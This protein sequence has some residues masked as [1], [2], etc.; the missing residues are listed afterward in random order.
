MRADQVTEA[1]AE[2]VRRRSRVQWAEDPAGAHA[3]GS[4]ALETPAAWA[5]VA[6][7]RSAEQPW[8]GDVF[9]FDRAEGQDVLEIGVGLGTD[10]LRWAR[11]GARVTGID[12]TDRCAGITRQRLESQGLAGSVHVM[13]AESLQFADD[14]FDIVYSFGVL[15][16]VPNPARAFQE[17]RRVLRPGG[18]FVGALYN[19]DSYVVLQ[20]RARRLLGREF[21]NESWPERLARVEHGDSGAIPY[22]RLFTAPT[23][24]RALAEAG[25]Q[26]VRVR[27]RHLG[28]V[29]LRGAL[30]PFVQD[31]LGRLAGWYLVHDAR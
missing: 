9:P 3:A 11:G 14:S 5:A 20:M 19:R 27:R 10:F 26:E 13:D 30:S 24:K 25:F 12:L 4:A 6:A 22:V 18:A 29:R 31:K 23:L 15:H 7:H 2:E 28:V 8:M 21:R 16:Q 17:I 1:W